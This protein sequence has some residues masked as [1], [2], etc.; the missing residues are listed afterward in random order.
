MET[1]PFHTYAPQPWHPCELAA[2]GSMRHP[3]FHPHPHL[4]TPMLR[5]RGILVGSLLA[6][7]CGLDSIPQD[8]RE[9]TKVYSE[10]EPLV[11]KVLAG[12][13]A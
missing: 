6:A 9:Q 4:L 3:H 13:D 7:Q 5:S 1:T 8:W 2:G 12:V 10:L 11:D